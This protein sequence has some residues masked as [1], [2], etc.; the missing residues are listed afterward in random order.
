LIYAPYVPVVGLE[1]L[2]EG[3]PSPAKAGSKFGDWILRHTTSSK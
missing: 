1:E 3:I 2:P